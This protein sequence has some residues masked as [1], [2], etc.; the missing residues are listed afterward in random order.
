VAC[1]GA[2]TDSDTGATDRR[3]VGRSDTAT[4]LTPHDASTSAT[5]GRHP[6]QT[7]PA[8]QESATDSRQEAPAAT[9]RRIVRSFTPTQWQIII[10]AATSTGPAFET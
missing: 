1:K 6:P 3:T 8:P 10:A 2:G 7:E 4:T 5:A 9:D